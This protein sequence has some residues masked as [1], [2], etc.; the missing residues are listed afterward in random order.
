MRR[1][2]VFVLL[3]ISLAVVS[4]PVMASTKLFNV[5][6]TANQTVGTCKDEKFLTTLGKDLEDLAPVFKGIDPKSPD[7]TA[8]VILTIATVRQKY[9]DM[10]LAAECLAAQIQTVVTLGN[11]GDLASLVIASQVDKKSPA[12]LYEEA[13]ERQ[14][15]RVEQAATALGNIVAGK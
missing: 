9:E 1:I 11:Y 14:G 12:K 5:T 4:V 7:T 15:K 8:A 13:I 6:N 2:T 10:D 3:A